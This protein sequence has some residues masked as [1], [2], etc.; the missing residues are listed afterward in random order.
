MK[1]NI[2]PGACI[3]I[4]D[5]EDHTYLIEK[6]LAKNKSLTL[7]SSFRSAEEAL[8]YLNRSANLPTV[9]LLDVNLPKMNGFD[10]LHALKSNPKLQATPVA[11]LTSSDAERDRI[12]AN[13]YEVIRY[14]IKPLDTK[15]LNELIADV[16]TYWTNL[17]S[18]A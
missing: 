1:Y 4:E 5:N 11:M 15:E 18:R 14:M 2:E 13:S 8:E 12:Q 3:L 17:E 9:I 16:T 10:F 7:V 6:C